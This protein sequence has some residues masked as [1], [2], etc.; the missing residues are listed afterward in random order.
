MNTAEKLV[1]LLA[2]RHLKITTAESCT[3][4]LVSAAITAVSGASEVLEGAIVAYSP[5]IKCELLGVPSETIEKY[6]VVSSETA[7][8]MAKGARECFNADCALALTG[9]AGPTGGDSENPVGTVWIGAVTPFGTTHR[10]VTLKA[11]I[12]GDRDA[13]RRGAAE[14][15]LSLMLNLLGQDLR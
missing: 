2:E 5:R 12:E 13:V 8:A 11:F 4:G 10:T 1:K 3:G 14:E 7:E 9:Y 15:A 6:G